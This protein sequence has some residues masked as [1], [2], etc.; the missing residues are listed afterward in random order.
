MNNKINILICLIFSII[1]GGIFAADANKFEI[2]KLDDETLRQNFPFSQGQLLDAVVQGQLEVIIYHYDHDNLTVSPFFRKVKFGEEILENA[3]KYMKPE[4]IKYVISREPRLIR[5]IAPYL[6][7]AVRYEFKPIFDSLLA[8]IVK[9]PDFINM[10]ALDW[11]VEI[12][13]MRHDNMQ[14]LKLFENQ[15][16]IDAIEAAPAKIK[17]HLRE[18]KNDLQKTLEDLEGIEDEEFFQRA[19]DALKKAQEQTDLDE[20]ALRDYTLFP[21]DRL[22]KAAESGQLDV[23]KNA[24]EHGIDLEKYFDAHGRDILYYAV[25]GRQPEIIKF[26]ISKIPLF[27][28]KKS[29][30]CALRTKDKRIIEPFVAPRMPSDEDMKKLKCRGKHRLS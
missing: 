23:L 27:R 22:F 15:E 8:P 24:F 1:S 25:H 14:K 30:Y 3:V 29:L 26:V 18:K 20:K 28:C 2:V 9:M 12:E 19:K 11:R 6:R 7:D 5:D 16:I 17:A 13:G 21:P 4:I 10:T